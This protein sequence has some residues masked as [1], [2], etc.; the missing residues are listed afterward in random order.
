[1]PKSQPATIQ[2]NVLFLA[3]EAAPYVKVGGLG[4][5]AGALPG[6]LQKVNELGD[7]PVKIDIRLV[8]PYH[9]AVRDKYPTLPLLTEYWLDAPSGRVAVKVYETRLDDVPVYLIDGEPIPRT[10]GVYSDDIHLDGRKY[11]FFSLAALL[12]PRE[13]NWEIHVLHANDWHTA[14]SIYAQSL[15]QKYDPF[16]QGIAR[17]LSIHN[18]PFMGAGAGQA[19]LDFGLPPSSDSRLPDWARLFPLP[20]G[21]TAAHRITTVSPGYAREILTPEFGC[22]LEG[23]LNNRR[24]DLSG[25]LNG[26]DMTAWDPAADSSLTSPF[27]MAALDARSANKLA[28]IRQFGLNTDPSIPLLTFIGRMDSQKG[29][30]IA[31]EALWQTI[32]LPWQVILLGTGDPGLEEGVRR[33]ERRLPSR[34]RGVLRFDAQLARQ[35]YGGSDLLLIPSRYEPCGTVQMIAMRYGCVPLARAT[36]GLMDTIYE[37][38][39]PTLNTG[40]LF[41]RPDAADMADALRRAF[42]LFNQPAAWRSLQINGMK[43]DFSWEHSARDYATLYLNVTNDAETV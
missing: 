13:I 24:S 22:G 37:K 10:G 39:D 34:V 38:S 8:L 41:S 6:Y 12:L 5:V 27:D 40:F 2:R 31:L 32:D 36:G 1:M 11:A 21:M 19:M 15:W 28:L 20:A 7:Q 14:L 43:Q 9:P 18:L 42:L 26:L 30:D 29:L 16:F 17:V 4:D 35:L 25:I 23:F 3:S 33:F